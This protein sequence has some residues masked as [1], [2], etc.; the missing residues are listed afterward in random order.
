M[1][2]NSFLIYGLLCALLVLLCAAIGYAIALRRNIQRA[3][4]KINRNIELIENLNEGVYRSSLEGRQLYANQSLV[5]LNGYD[6]LAE[7]LDS[8]KDI[9]R[10]WY[11]DPSRRA[12]F[13]AELQQHGSVTDFVSQIYRHKTREK[14][15]ISESARMVCDPKTRTPIFYEGTVRE[16]TEQVERRKLERKLNKLASNLSGGLF[17]FIQHGDGS[18][19]TPYL[20]DG[21]IRLTGIDLAQ[22]SEDA[23]SLLERIHPLD[24][25]TYVDAMR[26]SAL[27]ICQWEVEFRYCNT[28][29]SDEYLWLELTATPECNSDGGTIWHGHI[30]DISS[31]KQAEEKIHQLAYFDPLTE[32]PN[33][34]VFITRL[35]KALERN[36]RRNEYAGVIF[37]DLD[38]FKALN[39]THGHELGDVLLKQVAVRIRNSIRS[40]DTVSRFGG[41]EFVLLL[42][43]LGSNRTEATANA[44]TIARKILN[45][46][47]RG[48]DL[49]EVQHP[50]TPS[51]G[52]VLFDGEAPEPSE[53]I[54]NADIAMYEAKK[55]GRNNYSFFDPSTLRDVSRS[56]RL[57]NELHHGIRNNELALAFQP[58]VDGN[59]N[60]VGCE[61]LL[62]WHHPQHGTLHPASFVPMAEKSALIGELNDWVLTSAIKHLSRWNE[63]PQMQALSLSVNISAQQFHDN[64][65][66]SKLLKRLERSK[67]D[68]ALLTLEL[69]EKTLVGNLDSIGT[70]MQQLHSAG[71]RLSL[72]DFGTG[73]SSLSKINRFP[74]DEVKID[75]AFVAELEQRE[76]N[77]TLIEAILGMA[78]ALNL[79]TVA[80]HVGNQSQ[81]DFLNERG[82][83][84]FQ[85]YFYY[86]PLEEHALFEIASREN[87]TRLAA[88][89]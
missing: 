53:I 23:P 67:L 33:R 86:P 61:A 24:R 34:R 66:V 43:D 85:G 88:T 1:A 64:A 75:G 7:M 74:F 48:F 82:C 47:A 78:N 41:D 38:N 37:I 11:V 9:A 55:A 46:F 58:Q 52:I 17:Q 25:R 57:Q 18:F 10:E 87:G 69:T 51:M 39:D 31:R 15:W 84:R 21:F 60:I 83:R 12:E 56:Y 2:T 4:R 42:E 77:R 22:A 54:K 89:G 19:S 80:E 79:E 76:S 32:L 20:S 71:I 27:E 62:R 5:E 13:H 50:A 45:A 30:A 49:G 70:H 59:R 3:S 40:N 28:A 8:V 72:D 73:F 63:T 68:P 26:K 81:M 35:E 29:E 36:K 6:T 16:I 44:G 14:I 65:F